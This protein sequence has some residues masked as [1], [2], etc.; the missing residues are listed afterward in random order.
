MIAVFVNKKKLKDIA[1]KIYRNKIYH[2]KIITVKK[3][4]NI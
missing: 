2:K 3:I 1:N 4:F